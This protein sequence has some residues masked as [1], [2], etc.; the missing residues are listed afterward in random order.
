[1]KSLSLLACVVMLIVGLSYVPANAEIHRMKSRSS[2]S[3]VSK[4]REY[5]R[6]RAA[7]YLGVNRSKIRARSSC[8][9][10]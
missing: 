4:V 6:G 10:R 9:G 2:C 1:M 5:S 8:S 3:G 7:T